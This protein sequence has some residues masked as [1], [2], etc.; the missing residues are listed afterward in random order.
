MLQEG[1]CNT[2]STEG[3]G[4]AFQAIDDDASTIASIAKGLTSFA[5]RQSAIDNNVN[6]LSEQAAFL[7]HQINVQN[8]QLQALQAQ[9]ASNN[10]QMQPPNAAYFTL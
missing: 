10:F 5:K 3:Y 8:Q 2:M 6:T 7:M 4:S 9:N 1:T